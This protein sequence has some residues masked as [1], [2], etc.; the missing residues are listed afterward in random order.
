M[1][2]RDSYNVL[3]KHYDTLA[4]WA[5]GGKLYR[6]QTL[7]LEK[8]NK[9]SRV[10]VVGG[11]TGKWLTE[12]VVREGHHTIHFVD[13]SPAMIRRAGLHATGLNIEMIESSFDHFHSE[14]KFDAIIV[15]CFL[16]LFDDQAL[17]IIVEKMKSL[18]TPQACWLIVD[19]EARRWW[20][21]VLAK[22]MYFFFSLTTGLQTKQLPR[23]REALLEAGLYP[24]FQQT[25][26]W[27]FIQA[28]V[29]KLKP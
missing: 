25:Y 7:Y 4:D 5:F 9:G 13:S 2:K 3:A 24:T 26:W 29:W 20:H 10:L 11:G 21:G 28:S 16:D 8:I 22:A 19:F 15:F 23:W 17:S 12:S 1:S 18:T 27:D 6:A 14:Y